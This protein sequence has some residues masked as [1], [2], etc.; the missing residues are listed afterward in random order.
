MRIA[1]DEAN[2]TVVVVCGDV[3]EETVLALVGVEEEHRGSLGDIQCTVFVGEA[4]GKTQTAAFPDHDSVAY[5]SNN[6]H[7]DS[8]NHDIGRDRIIKLR[9]IPPLLRDA[10]AEWFGAAKLGEDEGVR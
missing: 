1:Y 6:H 3:S 10:V 8:D 7:D 2:I 4:E 5:V 9:Q